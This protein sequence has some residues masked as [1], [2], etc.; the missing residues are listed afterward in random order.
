[1]QTPPNKALNAVKTGQLEK[2]GPVQVRA[3]GRGIFTLF[4]T[5]GCRSATRNQKRELR[6]LQTAL[7]NFEHLVY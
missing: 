5:D 6:R 4:A 1:M 2:R 3:D 7:P